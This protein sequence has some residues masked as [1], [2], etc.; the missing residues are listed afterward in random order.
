MVRDLI[1]IHGYD[2]RPVKVCIAEKLQYM[3][4]WVSWELEPLAFK[5]QNMHAYMDF[6]VIVIYSCLR[7]H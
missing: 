1:H 3:R 6:K 5:Q 2:K 4:V 7:I